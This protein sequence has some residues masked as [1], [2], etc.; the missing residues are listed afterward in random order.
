MFTLSHSNICA[1]EDDKNSEVRSEFVIARGEAAKL[2]ESSKQIFDQM[3]RD[4]A[5]GRRCAVCDDSIAAG[6]RLVRFSR[7][8]LRLPEP[9]P[10]TKPPAMEVRSSSDLLSGT[11][12]QAAVELQWRLSPAVSVVALGLL[13]IPLSHSAPPE[14]R[15][16]RV[17]MGIL[18]YA[19][20]ANLLYLSR[21][22]I[23]DGALP[24]ALGLWWVHTAVL[25]VTVAWLRR[26]SRGRRS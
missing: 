25:T 2:F 5:P 7:N 18:A 22:W 16:G 13:A 9:E 19:A 3:A 15:G 1:S 4:N 12:P 11:D 23:N 6:S 14:G 17:L 21:S 20:Y 24:P 10:R 8:D 26:Q